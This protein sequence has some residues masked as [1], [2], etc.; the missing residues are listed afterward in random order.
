M[1]CFAVQPAQLHGVFVGCFMVQRTVCPRSYSAPGVGPSFSSKTMTRR[2]ALPEA[3]GNKI[4]N[5]VFSECWPRLQ[6]YINLPPREKKEGNGLLCMPAVGTPL[7]R[8]ERST[9]QTTE[10]GTVG[11]P[12]PAVDGYLSRRFRF[13]VTCRPFFNPSRGEKES[14]SPS[15]LVHGPA[16][17]RKGANMARNPAGAPERR[18]YPVLSKSL[19]PDHLAKLKQRPAVGCGEKRQS[20]WGEASVS[21]GLA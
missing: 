10:L 13:S 9:P 4:G 11:R 14:A 3:C 16:T 12:S 8:V 6:V 20:G 7:G 18:V 17:G 19:S 21:C 5:L 1:I 2:T 15:A